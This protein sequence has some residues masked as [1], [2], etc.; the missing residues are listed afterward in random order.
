MLRTSI[1]KYLCFVINFLLTIKKNNFWKLEDKNLQKWIW[2]EFIPNISWT[3]KVFN[4]KKTN[5]K[6]SK[7]VIFTTL[8]NQTSHLYNHIHT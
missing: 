5:I 8:K 4:D 3:Y 6:L 7:H 2:F 1:H